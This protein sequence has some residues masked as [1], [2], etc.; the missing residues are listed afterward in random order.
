ME[1]DAA[2]DNKRVRKMVKV[3][4]IP[5]SLFLDQAP[6]KTLWFSWP[7]SAA[8]QHDSGGLPYLVELTDSADDYTEH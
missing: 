5:S 6:Q 7:M 3:D 2:A 1:L 8:M 4:S